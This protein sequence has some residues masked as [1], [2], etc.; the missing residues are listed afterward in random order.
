M[1]LRNKTLYSFYFCSF[2]K[3]NKNVYD[4]RKYIEIYRVIFCIIMKNYHT[5][6]EIRIISIYFHLTNIEFTYLSISIVLEL[7]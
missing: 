6:A 3:Q 2:Y 7:Y 4:Y 5:H 1:D